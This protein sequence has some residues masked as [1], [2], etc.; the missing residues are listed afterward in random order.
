MATTIGKGFNP[1]KEVKAKVV[2]EAKE[3]KKDKKEEKPK[4]K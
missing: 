1:I 2:S 4:A 3:V